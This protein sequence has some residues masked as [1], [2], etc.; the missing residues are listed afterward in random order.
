MLEGL[1]VMEGTGLLEGP[2]SFPRPAAEKR[3]RGVW[4]RHAPQI[5]PA[6]FPG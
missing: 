1:R 4:G 5:T 2:E 6:P 3:A